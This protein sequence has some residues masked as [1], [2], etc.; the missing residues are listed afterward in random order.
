MIKNLLNLEE[1]MTNMMC[2]KSNKYSGADP[3]FQARGEGT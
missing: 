3:G 2:L 1:Y